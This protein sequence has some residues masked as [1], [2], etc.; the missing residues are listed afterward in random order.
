MDKRLS[1]TINYKEALSRV[2]DFFYASFNL[3]VE[4]VRQQRYEMALQAFRISWNSIL[5]VERGELN[6][7]RLWNRN[8]FQRDRAYCFYYYGIT[9]VMCG[10]IDELASLLREGEVFAFNDKNI[11]SARE[12]FKRVVS[13]GLAVEEGR[14]YL[15]PK[16]KEIENG[17]VR[18]MK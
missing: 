5:K 4:Y 2:P 6:E 18:C 12:I 11:L 7:S 14:E 1:L 8:V 15:K 17:K 3:G 13:E 16:L 9:I 10:K